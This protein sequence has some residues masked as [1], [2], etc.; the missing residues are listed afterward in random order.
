MQTTWSP[1]VLVHECDHAAATALSLPFA[2][3]VAGPEG[4][5]DAKGQPL[6]PETVLRDALVRLV[7]S[8]PGLQA[9]AGFESGWTARFGAG[10]IPERLDLSATD[11]QGRAAAALAGLAAAAVRAQGATLLRNRRLMRDLAELRLSHDQTQAAFAA[12]E[13]HAYRTGLAERQMLRH[14]PE[15]RTQPP[16][17]LAP[18]AQV[19]QRLPCDS[20]GLSDVALAIPKGFGLEE[21]E[22]TVALD[23]AESGACLAEWRIAAAQIRPGWLRLALDRAL[24]P[25]TQTPVLRLRWQGREQLRLASS[26]AHPDPRFQP[27]PGAPLL[28]LQ[29]WKHL[30]GTRT[31]PAAG[32]HLARGSDTVTRWHLGRSHMERAAGP[33]PAKSGAALDYSAD[34]GG[35]MVRPG[36]DGQVQAARLDGGLAAGV[37]QVSGGVKT[38]QATGPAVD[39]ALA[40]APVATRPRSAGTLPAFAPGHVSDWLRLP[41]GTWG[42]LHLFLPAPLAEDHDLYLMTR[43]APGETAPDAAPDTCFFPLVAEVAHDRG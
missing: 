7:L 26:F 34:F 21:G 41:A 8:A 20:A 12:L 19:D 23:L 35:L 24:G 2:L 5:R 11:P 33:G 1:V 14:L 22:L 36:A 42:A 27:R 30:P 16:C 25:D 3:A 4:V 40:A 39:Y 28:A 13:D 10:S 37:A 9:D 31:P 32:S 43:L 29:I 38:E 18:G 6:A 15:Q 17:L